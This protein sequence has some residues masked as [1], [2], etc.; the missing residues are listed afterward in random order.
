MFDPGRR[1][2][3]QRNGREKGCWVYVPAEA[4]EKALPG[5]G[6]TLPHYRTWASPRGSVL[7]RLYREP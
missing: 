1:R 6:D 7:L 4:L 2:K 5:L 3:A